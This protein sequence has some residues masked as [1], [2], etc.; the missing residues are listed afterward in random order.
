MKKKLVLLL[1]FVMLCATVF[2]A[3]SSG[4]LTGTW[5]L[6][7]AEMLGKEVSVDEIGDMGGLENAVLKFKSGG[8]V[9]L[10]LGEDEN[11]GEWKKDGDQVSI[12]ADGTK[13]MDLTL[14][15]SKLILEQSGIKLIFKK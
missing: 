14:D 3:C 5:K 13:V 10:S 6:S 12:I 9:T 7:G 2:T 11:S 15:G 8:K 1:A 4:G